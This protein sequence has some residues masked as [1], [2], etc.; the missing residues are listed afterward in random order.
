[1]KILIIGQAPPAVKQALPY[2]TTLLYDMLGWVGID[3]ATAQT[4][5]EFEAMVDTF[6]GHG[7]NGHLLPTDADMREHYLIVLKDKIEKADKI[8]VLGKVA[9]NALISFGAFN[10]ATNKKVLYMIHPSKR[11]YNKIMNTKD[12]IIKSLNHFF[13]NG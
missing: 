9:E 11:N 10:F 7:T 3:K 1:M 2:D 4:M 12:E 5:F 6:T 13:N 8:L